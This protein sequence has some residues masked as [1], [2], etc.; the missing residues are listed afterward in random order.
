[1][2]NSLYAIFRKNE[3]ENQESQ[4]GVHIE[5]PGRGPAGKNRHDQSSAGRD[6]W[7]SKLSQDPVQGFFVLEVKTGVECTGNR[8]YNNNHNLHWRGKEFGLPK[9]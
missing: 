4:V 2:K 7:I 5:Y 9:S 1:L 3:E 6:R 8:A